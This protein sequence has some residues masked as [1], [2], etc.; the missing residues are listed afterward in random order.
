MRNT[1]IKEIVEITAFSVTKSSLSDESDNLEV[2]NSDLVLPL[3]ISSK[4][5][6]FSTKRSN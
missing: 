5:K 6:R 4:K 2:V 3:A 1:Q